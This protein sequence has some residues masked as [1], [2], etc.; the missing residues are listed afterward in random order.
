[1]KQIKVTISGISPLLMDR[2]GEAAE[3]SVASS[4]SRSIKVKENITP[5]EAAEAAAYKTANGE[6]YL[7]GVNLYSALIAAGGFHKA[8]RA[9]ITTAKTSLVPAGLW[10]ITD[11]ILLGTKECEVDSRPIV[12]QPSN[13]RIMKHRARLEKWSGDVVLEYDPEIFSESIIRLLVD[14]AGSKLGVGSFRPQRK[15]PFGRFVVT[16]WKQV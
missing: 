6:L 10:V 13:Y 14:D 3:A 4:N 12:A 11:Q 8:G 1:M 9:K 15:G 16:S 7:P 2:F 5:R